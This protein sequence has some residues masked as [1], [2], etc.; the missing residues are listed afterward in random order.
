[1]TLARPVALLAIVVALAMAGV[2]DGLVVSSTPY[3]PTLDQYCNADADSVQTAVDSY[4]G[5]TGSYPIDVAALTASGP[6]GPWLRA[7]PRSD[8]YRI[9]LDNAGNVLVHSLTGHGGGNWSVVGP[10][11]CNL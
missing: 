1:V 6:Q 11:V 10:P 7:A 3:H 9:S 8:R 2:V 4:Q 5:Q